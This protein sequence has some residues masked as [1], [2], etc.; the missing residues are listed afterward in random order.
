[1]TQINPNTPHRQTPELHVTD[2]RSSSSTAWVVAALVAVVAIIAVAFMVTS[3]QNEGTD[4][5]AIAA[6]A[7]QGRAEGMLSG[8]QS[9]LDSARA[10]AASATDSTAAQAS[11]AAAD[12]RA[13]A[14]DAARSADA[15]ASR[16]ATPAPAA[17]P[18]TMGEPQP[19]PQ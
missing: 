6:A 4:P 14:A 1:M 19:A 5:A 3:G 18:D 11:M 10:A 16:A 9:S 2:N 12:A 7:D 15:A 13:A 8:A 17:Q